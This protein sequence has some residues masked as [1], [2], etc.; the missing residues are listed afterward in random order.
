ML[1]SNRRESSDK[2]DFDTG[3]IDPWC[4]ANCRLQTLLEPPFS[5]RGGQSEKGYIFKI[6]GGGGEGGRREYTYWI[7]A[8]RSRQQFIQLLAYQVNGLFQYPT[9]HYSVPESK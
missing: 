2:F 8:N 6:R 1:Y 9:L 4:E 7:T 5:G 3:T